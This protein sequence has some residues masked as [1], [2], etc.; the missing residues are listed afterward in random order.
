[1]T[2]QRVTVIDD[3]PELLAL[4]ED[5]LGGEGVKLTLLDGAASFE[6]IQRS[7]PTLL[8]V[9]LRLG[10]DSLPGWEVIR[11]A[12]SR[13]SFD[14]VPIVVCSAALDQVRQHESDLEAFP[15]TYLLPKPFSLADLDSVLH[16][17]L[18]GPAHNPGGP[19][20]PTLAAG[21]G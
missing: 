20:M 6:E 1:M 16:E 19:A 9:D 14:E 12:R 7:D 18:G 11:T 15:R 5:V 13:P 10:T 17:A 8:V 3:S 4:F 2:P 21:A